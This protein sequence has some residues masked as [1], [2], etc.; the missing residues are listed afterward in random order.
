MQF[1]ANVLCFMYLFGLCCCCW[2][3]RWCCVF[4]VLHAFDDECIGKG[5][6]DHDH[7]GVS[8]R[9]R[10]LLNLWLLKTLLAAHSNSCC[11]Y[12][13]TKTYPTTISLLCDIH[14]QRNERWK[15]YSFFSRN[16]A[17]SFVYGTRMAIKKM[18]LI[19]H[20]VCVCVSVQNP[21]SVRNQICYQ[22]E[23]QA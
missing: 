15:I 14:T 19:K 5:V 18:K 22:C 6:N 3:G 21:A 10:T 1:C 9:A 7:S 11:A 8:A 16:A 20:C 17:T 12:F 4:C 23:F 13:A 2:C